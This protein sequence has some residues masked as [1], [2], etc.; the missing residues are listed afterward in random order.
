[1]VDIKLKSKDD[2]GLTDEQLTQAIKESIE[3][4]DKDLERVLLIP[5]DF[6]RFHSGAGKLTAIYY[7]LLK[8]RCSI[9]ILP[10][11]GTHMPMSDEEIS[12]MFG[13]DI[14]RERFIDHN[15]R[16][17]VVKIGEVPSD[18]IKEISEGL[19]DESIDV[20]VNKLLVSGEYDI[21]ISLGQVVPHEVV[22]MANYGKNIFVGC[23]GKN[24]INSTHM[25]GA[26]YGLERL[27]GKD[28]SPVRKVFDY[29][30][31]HFAQD[32][33]LMYVL[34]VT[35]E[36]EGAT[37]IN[38]LFIGRD[39]GVFEAAVA[40]SQEKNLTFVDEPFKKVVV[41]LDERE[42]KST[43]LGNKSVYRTRMAI[44]DDGELIVLGPGVRQFGEDAGIDKLIR[45]Y[46]YVGRDR[47][48]E[49]YNTEED[50]K[51]NQSVAAHLIHGSSDGRFKIT[52]AV[53]HLTK[54]EI[55]GV[56]F[57]YM[58][59]EEAYKLYDPNKLKDGYNTLENGEEI[60]YISN[61]AIGLWVDRA[62]FE[63]E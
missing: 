62:K 23:G 15:W 21:I 50:L 54:E 31:E 47:V 49:L 63:G 13:D 11:L 28:H 37:A 22:G 53:K 60:F 55:E 4:L 24:M 26:V 6:T 61:P 40:L 12:E 1:M 30:E 5:P 57:E 58:P 46:G 27:M 9:D 42:F 17:D 48:L 39:R 10:A 56:N 51:T 14:P 7:D 45:K 2:F 44:A 35:T 34:T 43:W 18:F 20:E 52:Y 3:G 38:G 25:L 36:Y 8:D 19:M 59:I 29:A 16:E 32:I 33:P 41:Y